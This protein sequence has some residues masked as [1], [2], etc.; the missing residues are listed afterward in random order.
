MKKNCIADSFKQKQMAAFLED[1]G[2]SRCDR[3]KK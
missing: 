1:S 2:G 3:R